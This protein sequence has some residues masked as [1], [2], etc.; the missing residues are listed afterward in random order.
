MLYLIGFS[1]SFN[2]KLLTPSYYGWL[3]Q[4]RHS[5]DATT[6]CFV[7]LFLSRVLLSVLPIR[8][9]RAHYTSTLPSV[10]PEVILAGVQRVCIVRQL[11]VSVSKVINIHLHFCFTDL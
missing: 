5:N 3:R 11:R 2:K 1:K 6:L 4:N 7:W 9:E 10:D 8:G